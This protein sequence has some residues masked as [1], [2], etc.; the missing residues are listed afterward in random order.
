MKT[1]RTQNLLAA[2]LAAVALLG[3]GVRYWIDSPDSGPKGWGARVI[4]TFLFPK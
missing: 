4:V 3:A 2:A 1:T